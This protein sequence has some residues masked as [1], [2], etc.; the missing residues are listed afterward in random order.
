MALTR[1][2][3]LAVLCLGVPLLGACAGDGPVDPGALHIVGTHG[4]WSTAFHWNAG[5]LTTLDA[6]DGDYHVA[7][8]SVTVLDGVA[9]VGAGIGGYIAG[10]R[11]GTWAY[12]TVSGWFK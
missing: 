6:P 12:D 5:D 2:S 3:S 1:T 7:A 11:A 4:S 10:S 9:V 8:T